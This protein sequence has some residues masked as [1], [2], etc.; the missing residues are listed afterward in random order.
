MLYFEKN[1]TVRDVLNYKN[2]EHKDHGNILQV[3]EQA[4]LMQV[5]CYMADHHIGVV[6]VYDD[7]HQLCGL[8][9]ERDIIRYIAINGQNAF[10]LSINYMITRDIRFCHIGDKLKQVAHDMADFNI[11]HIAV[12]NE[13]ESYVGV[14]SSSDIEFFAGHG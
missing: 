6:F 14:I 4:T 7:E 13:N 12:K 9:S 8:I 2:E 5:I 3:P 1:A 11:R 10:K